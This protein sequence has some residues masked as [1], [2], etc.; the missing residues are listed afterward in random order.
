MDIQTVL[1]KYGLH[2]AVALI[3]L[4]NVLPKLI[5][6]W[7]WVIDKLAP[8]RMEKIRVAAEEAKR[9][10]EAEFERDQ[11]DRDL[12]ERDIIAKEQTAKALLLIDAHMES[13]NRDIKDQ[14]TL[15]TTGLITANQSLAVL[16]DRRRQVEGV[17]KQG[18]RADD[19]IS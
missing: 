15:L 12:R 1:D 16:L 13:S 6:A 7:K 2:A 17:I 19:I 8:E 9:E 14:L 10:D 18:T 4:T 3:M 5:E 11:F